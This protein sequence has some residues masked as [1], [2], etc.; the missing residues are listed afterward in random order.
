LRTRGDGTLSAL[1]ISK[2][3]IHKKEGSYDPLFL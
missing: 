3:Y 2:L 1:I